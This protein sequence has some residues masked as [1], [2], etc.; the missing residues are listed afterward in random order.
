MNAAAFQRAFIRFH[1][2]VYER[3]GGRIGRRLMV[4]PSLLLTTTG[5]R[6]GQP[7]TAVLVYAP[8]G[9]EV[10]V[11]ASNDGQDRPPAWLLNIG[12]DPRV[13]VRIGRRRGPATA[14][15]VRAGDPDYPRRW[16]LVNAN[17]HGRYDGYQRRT[18]RPIELV[19]I[20]PDAGGTDAGRLQR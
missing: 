16:A 15:I 18:S 10:V 13:V 8:D 14:R 2:A 6:T 4:V 19:A 17:N 11:V 12:A 20:R 9:D 1:Q 7:R 5:R 3:S